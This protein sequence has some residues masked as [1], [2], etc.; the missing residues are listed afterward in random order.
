M[1]L[2]EHWLTVDGHRYEV[3]ALTPPGVMADAPVLVFLHEGLGC[4]ALWRDFPARL[5]ARTG[6]PAFLYSRL[7]YGRS[8]PG[9]RPLPLDYHTPEALAV[10]PAIL[11]TAGIARPILIGH[12]DGGTIALLNAAAHITPPP[13]AI[14]TL[15]AHVFNEEITIAGIERTKEAFATAGLRDRLRRYHGENVDGAF[16]GWC[17]AWLDPAF[18]DWNIEAA[19]PAI[20]CP[21]LVMQGE[22]DPYGSPRQVAAIC[23]GAAGHAE[24][25][26]LPGL[27]HAP[28]LEAPEE[29]ARRIADFLARQRVIGAR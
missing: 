15:A 6:L 18:R 21:V 24:P 14:V 22:A 28:H 7:G 3:A 23:A 10:L 1:G 5:A 8:D 11:R 27:G 26:L 29:V 20:A 4:V 13:L 9:A 12:S 19:L 17:D 16:H 2:H 25:A